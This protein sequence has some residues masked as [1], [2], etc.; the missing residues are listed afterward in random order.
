MEAS[1]V[2]PA[3]DLEHQRNNRPYLQ[4]GKEKV[5]S[6]ERGLHTGSPQWPRL[7]GGLLI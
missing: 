4:E 7:R 5:T 2:P 6:I 1:G 3:C